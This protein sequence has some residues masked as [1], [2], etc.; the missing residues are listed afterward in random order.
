MNVNLFFIPILPSECSDTVKTSILGDDINWCLPLEMVTIKSSLEEIPF[1]ENF[2]PKEFKHVT[3][4]SEECTLKGNLAEELFIKK[5]KENNWIPKNVKEADEYDYKHHVDLMVK[6][7]NNEE[8]WFDIKCMR[9]LRRGWS[10]QSEYMWIELT[11]NGWLFGGKVTHI[12]QQIGHNTFAIFDRIALSNYVRS[13]VRTD[14]PVVSYAEQ[15]F[16][17]VYMRESSNNKKNVLSLVNTYEAFKIAGCKI[18]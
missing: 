1:P 12:A 7:P 16:N 17:R 13:V 2:E 9:S 10:P 4:K 6:M 3:Y 5:V 18:I 15:S 14:L 11:L 8:C